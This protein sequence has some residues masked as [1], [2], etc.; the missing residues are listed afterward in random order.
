MFLCKPNNYLLNV[1]TLSKIIHKIDT[2]KTQHECSISLNLA[3]LFTL[4][5]NIKKRQPILKE[6]K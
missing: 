1:A 6:Q 2:Q 3:I 4:L 5:Q